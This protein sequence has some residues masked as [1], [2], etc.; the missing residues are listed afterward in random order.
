MHLGGLVV[1]ASEAAAEASPFWRLEL[2]A[3][4]EETSSDRPPVLELLAPLYVKYD[5]KRDVFKRWD[6][7]FCGGGSVGWRLQ[8]F[9]PARQLVQCTLRAT[10]VQKPLLEQTAKRVHGQQWPPPVLV[11]GCDPGPSEER[12]FGMV[13]RAR[14]KQATPRQR[15]TLWGT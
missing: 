6:G 9:L 15:S 11:G 3:L 5:D 8:Q 13:E 10:H 14:E 2:G 12:T 4:A 7:A 1:E